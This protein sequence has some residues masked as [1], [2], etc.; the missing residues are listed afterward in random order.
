[1]EPKAYVAVLSRRFESGD[2]SIPS[3]AEITSAFKE[4]LA[5]R[6]VA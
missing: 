2:G 1:M 3:E 6:K 5:G 4:E